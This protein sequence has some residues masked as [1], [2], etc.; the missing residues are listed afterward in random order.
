[1]TIAA[2]RRDDSRG[3]DL[4]AVIAAV[5]REHVGYAGPLAP[6]LRLIEDLE[7]DSVK[8]LTLVVELENRF[9]IRLE[10]EDEAEIV[11][12]GDLA[13][14]IADKLASGRPDDAE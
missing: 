7:L 9:R 4:L 10:P 12:V 3:N 13:L 11:T 14:V 6:E 8:A 2:E 1:M 5:A